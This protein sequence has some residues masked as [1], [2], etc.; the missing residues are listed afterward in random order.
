MGSE[1]RRK[2]ERELMLKEAIVLGAALG[3]LVSPAWAQSSGAWN[4]LPDRFQVDAGYFDLQADNS[5]LYNGPQGG[6]GNVSLEKDLGQNKQVNTFWVDGTWRV[7]RRHQLKL[8]YTQLS[9][10]RASYSLQRDFVWG[11]QTYTAGLTANT[12]TSS[13]IL[14][15]YY[16]F[17]AF[18]NNRFE[19]GPAIG[20]GRLTMSARIRATGTGPGGSSRSLDQSASLGAMTGAIGAYTEG[21]LAKKLMVQGDFLYIKVTPNSEEA[22]VT[23]W[24]LAANYFAFRGVGLGV[25]YKYNK[26]TQARGVLDSKLGGSMTFQGVQAFLSFRF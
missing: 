3:C 5:L 4:G 13:G 19:I 17:A 1:A 20:I 15:G 6:G 8:S 14:G 11:G 22:S 26:Y 24:R 16:R 7:G 25:Q 21:W 12:S 23:D 18:R 9:R 10:D 2:E